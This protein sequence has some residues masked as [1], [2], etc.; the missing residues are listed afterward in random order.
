MSKLR[1]ITACT[2]LVRFSGALHGVGDSVAPSAGHHVVVPGLGQLKG[3]DGFGG[4]SGVA[5][6]GGIP[7]AEAP[8][9]E[10]RWQP[11]KSHGP[12]TGVREATQFGASC[13]QPLT[14]GANMSVGSVLSEDCLFL[15]IATPSSSVGSSRKLPVMFWIHG[16]AYL[17]GSG[18]YPLDA[19][20]ASSNFSVVVT[21][22]NYRLNFFGFLA[23]AEVK[24]RTADG[25]A[26]N[27]G[28]QDQRMALMW[29]RD[30]I[31]P[32]GGDGQDVTIFGESAGGNSVM[33][34]LAQA[35][36]FS[37]YK[38]AIIESGTWMDGAIDMQ[39]ASK[40]Y[41][42]LLSSA[43]CKTL[44]CLVALSGKDLAQ[45]IQKMSF[46][47]YLGIAPVVDG[48]SLKN[49]PK[50]IMLQGKHNTKSPVIIG[51][52]REE[53]ASAWFNHYPHEMNETV[54]DSILSSPGFF[55]KKD[56]AEIK[57]LYDPSQYEYPAKL[58]NYS[59][60]WWTISRMQTDM[61]PGGQPPAAN[62]CCFGACAGR[63]VARALV[64]GGSE[65]YVYLFA[66][67]PQTHS[68]FGPSTGPG[69][70]IVAHAMEIPFVFGDVR[71]LVPSDE[72]QLALAMATY[73]SSFAALGVPKHANLPAWQ[74]FDA[75]KRS[76]QGVLRF[77]GAPSSGGIKMQFNLRGD[78]CDYWE[79]RLPQSGLQ[80][81]V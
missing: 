58:G 30:H 52:N 53:L 2:L 20:V 6:F 42:N 45:V 59:Q 8:V 61:I 43:S 54:F 48:I 27:F 3:A 74:A 40:L 73:W 32:F 28:I 31:S 16:G 34:H 38:K 46:M 77:D 68:Q 35:Q 21:S 81:V 50:A 44:D 67:P 4:Y 65:V 41:G 39:A 17:Q 49:T 62:P 10:L 51:S 37:L 69:N 80:V 76:S 33:N 5:Q 18:N 29:L 25:S 13:S 1:A 60:W 72:K 66:K 22:A 55:A 12:W 9:G 70:V 15:N 26:G 64:N 78:A 11:P 14:P 19:L 56:L 71:D 7:Y 47:D 57:K 79:S 23:S 24:G 63:S 36:S 75:S